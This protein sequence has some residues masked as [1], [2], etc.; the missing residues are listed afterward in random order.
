MLHAG[1]QTTEVTKQKLSPERRQD[2]T[3][4]VVVG[5][6]LGIT[7]F[8]MAA[9]GVALL[10]VT[11]IRVMRAYLDE[12]IY[13]PLYGFGDVVEPVLV[14]LAIGVPMLTLSYH[15]LAETSRGRWFLAGFVVVELAIFVVFKVSG[16]GDLSFAAG[17]LTALAIAVFA[18]MRRK[19]TSPDEPSSSEEPPQNLYS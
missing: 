14:F 2:R 10:G 18:L 19:A 1:R 5:V 13:K 6:V 8:V 15:L 7:G 9:P 16:S 3:A 17:A 12:G 4:E 11:A